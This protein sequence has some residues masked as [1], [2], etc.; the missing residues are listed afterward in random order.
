MT[1]PGATLPEEF[2]GRHVEAQ[3][4]LIRAPGP[5]RGCGSPPYQASSSWPP[6]ARANPAAESR[7]RHGG[8]PRVRDEEQDGIGERR[9]APGVGRSRGP[10]VPSPEPPSQSPSEAHSHTSGG[11]VLRSHPGPPRE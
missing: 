3:S 6:E 10:Q 1:V 7:G 2:Q 4:L 8:S 9:K 11:A 5:D